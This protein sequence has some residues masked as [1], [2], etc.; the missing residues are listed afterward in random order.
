M[1]KFDKISQN[2]TKFKYKD[3]NFILEER[4]CGVYG[5]YTC[6]QLYQLTALK[7]DYLKTIAWTSGNYYNMPGQDVLV[8]QIITAMECREHAIKYIDSLLK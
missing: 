7:K 5:M 8:R 4:P 6:V 1:V 3:I 2:E